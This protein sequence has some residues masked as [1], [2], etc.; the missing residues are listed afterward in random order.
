M[1]SGSAVIDVNNTSG[2]FPGQD[3]GVVAIFTLAKYPGGVAGPQTQNIA[4]SKDGGFTFQY[5]INNPV[6]NS[7]SSQ[8]RD[9]KVIFYKDHWVMVVSYAQEFTIGIFTSPDLKNWT[10]S[11]NFTHVGLLGTQYEC[12]NLVEMP[13]TGD[14][15]GNSTIYVLQIS[16]Q[17]GAPLGGSIS[18]YFPGTFDGYTFTA[19]DA[20]AR[21]A[22]F[23][24][25]NYAGQFFYGVPSGADAVSIA[26][27]A[28]WQYAQQ[29]PTGNTENFRS[30]MSVPRRNT[31]VAN[32]TRVGYL[33]TS[34][35]YDLTPVLGPTLAK[36]ASFAN[37]TVAL[38]YSGVSSG[39]L[40]F[41]ANVTN[42]NAS[43][44]QS[45]TTLNFTFMSP[46]TGEY[47]QGGFY[48]GGDTP[49]FINRGGI[50]GF[51]NV[52]FTDK[53]SI[54]DIYDGVTWTLS[55]VIDRSILEVF[56]DSG[57][58][59]ATTT[60]YPT[61]PLS[62]MTLS[63]YMMP[64][65]ANVSVAV[66]ALKSAWA[67]YENATGTVV[68]NITTSGNATRATMMKREPLYEASF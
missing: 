53:F 10:H 56:V 21:I 36:N 41:E 57:R 65:G 43:L 31:I 4:W 45:Y 6:I 54:A 23:G 66:Y 39:A 20:A 40:Y 24:K 34:M 19:V 29:V 12:P 58:H 5:Y 60:F 11:S 51:D 13:L 38:D 59:A 1:F 55:G 37:A 50:R 9:P 2:F 27:A 14:P 16:L 49:F 8:F 44:I 30:V 32:A 22:D 26:W 33:L 48:F 52:F 42:L 64:V 7:T 18:Q 61:Q 68:G 46:Q 15:S 28:N 62:I 3:N 67:Q 17:P 63:T 47:L 25:D 35:P